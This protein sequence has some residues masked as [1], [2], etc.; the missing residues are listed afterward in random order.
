M[1]RRERETC[2][3]RTSRPAV[4][5]V[6]A[7]IVSV[8]AVSA[9]GCGSGAASAGVGGSAGAGSAGHAAD[10]AAGPAGAAAVQ[11]EFVSVVRQVLPSVVEI[12]TRSGLGSGVVFDSAGDIITNAH[13]VGDSTRFEVLASGLRGSLAGSLVGLCTADDLAVIKVSAAHRL[14]PAAFDSAAV[15]VGDLVLAMGSPLGLDSSV[16]EGIVSAV[17]RVVNEPVSAGSAE[18]TLRGT[19]QTSAAINP[20]NSGGALVNIDGQVIGIPTLTAAGEQ[21]SADGIGF[22]ISASTAV[23]VARQLADVGRAGHPATCS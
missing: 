5:V 22:A 7:A 16:T 4:A 15:E 10:P 14:R 18:V 9:A 8:L 1:P 23:R 20:G 12:R 6:A 17:G 19:I 13:V 2:R 11:Q 3:R 21:G